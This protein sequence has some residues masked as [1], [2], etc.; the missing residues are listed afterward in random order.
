MVWTRVEGIETVA[1]SGPKVLSV[2][3]R[4]LP[5]MSTSPDCSASA[6]V[7]A[8]TTFFT[9]IRVSGGGPPQWPG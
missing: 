7:L 2:S 1:I 9:E 6:R 5:A 3:G 8:S 4:I